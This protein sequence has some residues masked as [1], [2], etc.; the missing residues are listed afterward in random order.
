MDNRERVLEI[1]RRELTR[2]GARHK[3]VTTEG[4]MALLILLPSPN[5][6]ELHG[7]SVASSCSHESSTRQTTRESSQE[8]LGQALYHGSPI[9]HS[10]DTEA[11]SGFC[12][13]LLL[14][15]VFDLWTFT[16]SLE[17]C[18][19]A[20]DSPMLSASQSGTDSTGE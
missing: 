17:Q 8:A 3:F 12:R 19:S 7:N 9:Y 18:H 15:A 10:P 1:V 20:K 4:W 14:D 5:D 13:L 2:C 11:L 16:D 6:Q